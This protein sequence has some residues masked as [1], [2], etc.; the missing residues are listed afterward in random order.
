MLVLMGDQSP[1]TSWPRPAP[2]RG[3]QVPR[4]AAV[5]AGVSGKPAI[6][7][8]DWLLIAA[9][10]GR[11]NPEPRGE[12]E[13]FRQQRGYQAH[14]QPD[15]LYNLREDLAQRRN[16]CAD[17]PERVKMLLALLERYQREGRS[18]R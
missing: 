8:G 14:D 12:P 4:E 13:W 6:Q 18:V 16:R 9:P 7:Q 2:L 17:E 11:E 3:E 1:A 10:T 15:E 5:F